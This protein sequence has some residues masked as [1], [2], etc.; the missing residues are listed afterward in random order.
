MG[1]TTLKAA[2]ERRRLTQRQLEAKSGVEQ[3]SISR[4]ENGDVSDPLWST[5]RKLESALGLK[6]GTLVFGPEA[7]KFESREAKA[8]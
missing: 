2:R 1:H 3:T 5:V 8:S 7:A 6:S 4:I